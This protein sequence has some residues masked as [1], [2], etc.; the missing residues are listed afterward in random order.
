MPTPSATLPET[1]PAR[2]YDL[3]GRDGFQPRLTLSTTELA[4]FDRRGFHV[5]E[6]L[7]TQQEVDEIREACERVSY[8]EYGTGQAP[9]CRC[10]E[11]TS[12]PTAVCKIDNSW[13]SDRVIE[14]AVTSPRLGAI[15][16]QLIGADGI[17]LWHD[18]YLRKPAEGGG[19]VQWHQDWMFWQ[20]IDR[21]RTVTCWIALA[22]VDVDMGPMVFLEGSQS[23]G[24]RAD[25]KPVDWT[26]GGLPPSPL[27]VGYASVPLVVKAGQVA[28]HHGASMHASDINHSPRTR[29]SLVSH[30]MAAD[31]CYR[32]GHGHMCISKMQELNPVPQA[33]ERFHGP[34]FPWVW[35]ADPHR[36][37]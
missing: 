33:G 27:G 1:V 16:A 3:E 7:F 23:E 20:A 2:T 19:I 14:A 15:A 11:P 26:G 30:V 9:D 13:K 37:R 17:R 6:T 25:L 31:C 29:Y 10:W 22:D 4:E 5:H 8:G 28:F 34:Q 24:L 21:C 35:R 18:Q 36:S 32:P 12:P